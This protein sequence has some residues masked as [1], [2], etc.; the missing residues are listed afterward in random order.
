LTDRNPKRGPHD[1]RESPVG[2][3]ITGRSSLRYTILSHA[4]DQKSVDTA[5]DLL[6]KLQITAEAKQL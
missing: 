5:L 1:Y 3:F 2:Y 4:G 6:N